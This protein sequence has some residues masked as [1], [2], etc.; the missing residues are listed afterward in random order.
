MPPVPPPAPPEPPPLEPPPLLGGGELEAGG[1]LD[2]GGELVTG[3]ALG[4]GELGADEPVLDGA[5]LAV[6]LG[7]GGCGLGRSAGNA[8]VAGG[9]VT[10]TDA[11]G[12]D[13]PTGPGVLVFVPPALATSSAAANSAA[14]SSA[15]S[16]TRAG[17]ETVIDISTS[18]C[19]SPARCRRSAC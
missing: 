8:E 6:C 13:S 15:S 5:V 18:A 2:A 19:S 3:G 12:A 1:E 9:A 17:E 11:A 7:F 16:P 4:E 14:S 10:A